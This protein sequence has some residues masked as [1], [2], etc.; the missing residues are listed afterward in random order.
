MQL[1]SSMVIGRLSGVFPLRRS[2]F[3]L[4][5]PTCTGFVFRVSIKKNKMKKKVVNSV[6]LFSVT[7]PM[8]I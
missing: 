3:F 7:L 8:H 6:L 1:Y 2:F 4:S 5:V